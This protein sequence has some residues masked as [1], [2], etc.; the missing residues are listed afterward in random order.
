M[1]V[2]FSFCF[3]KT[4]ILGTLIFRLICIPKSCV[5]IHFNNDDNIRGNNDNTCSKLCQLKLNDMNY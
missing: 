2:N 3:M 4:V 5:V 1:N